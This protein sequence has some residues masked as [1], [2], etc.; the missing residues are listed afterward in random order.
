MR[1]RLALLGATV[2]IAMVVSVAAAVAAGDDAIVGVANTS[3]SLQAQSAQARL[4]PGHPNISEFLVVLTGTSSGD[5]SLSGF[6]RV[7]VRGILDTNTNNGAAAWSDWIV[8]S[9]T[10]AR[11]A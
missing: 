9:S 6:N 11:V 1:R 2:T 8:K 5:P 4:C 3:Y 7:T 10:G